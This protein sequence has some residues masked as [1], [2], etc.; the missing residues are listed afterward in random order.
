[1]GNEGPVLTC[2]VVEVVG[3]VDWALLT[4]PGRLATVNVGFSASCGRNQTL[5]AVGDLIKRNQNLRAWT[6]VD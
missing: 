6:A 5:R 3:T 4:V 2:M 1:M